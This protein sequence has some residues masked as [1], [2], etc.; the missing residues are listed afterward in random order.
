MGIKCS[1]LGKNFIAELHTSLPHI[2]FLHI[3]CISM[4]PV[5]KCSYIYIY[6]LSVHVLAFYKYWERSSY[7]FKMGC[8]PEP[9]FADFFFLEVGASLESDALLLIQ[10]MVVGLQVIWSKAITASWFCVISHSQNEWF[11]SLTIMRCLMTGHQ[12]HRPK[13]LETWAKWKVSSS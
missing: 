5:H 7:G 8:F 13:L 2:C 11:D 12:W 3:Q 10:G 1:R 4:L 9:Q 6:I